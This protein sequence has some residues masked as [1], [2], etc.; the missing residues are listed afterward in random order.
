MALR[1]TTDIN[2]DFYDK[3]YILINAKQNDKKS[4]FLLITCYDH[5][6][7]YHINSVEYSAYIRYKKSDEYGVFNFCEINNKGKIL[8]ELTEQMLSTSGICYADLVIINKGSAVVD[9]NTGEIAMIDNS[10]ILSTMTFCIDVS[11]TAFDNSEIESSYEYDGLNDL[12]ERAEAEYS[13]VV[14]MAKSYAVGGTDER[15]NEDTDNAKYYYEQS[16]K[17]SANAETYMNAASNS[18]SSARESAVDA[19]TSAQNAQT[20]M[21]QAK[22]Y[23]DNAQVSANEAATSASAAATSETN[24]AKSATNAQNSMTSASS[25]AS[26]ASQ[27]ATGA[28]NYYLQAEAIVNGLNGAFL[29]KGTITFAELVELKESGAMAAGH[30][31]QISDDFTTDE[32]FRVSGKVCGAGTSVYY[33]VDD[34]FDVFVG[35][36]VAGVKGESETGYRTGMVNI[37]PENVGAIPTAD[38]ATVDEVKNYLSII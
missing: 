5:G 16:K 15:V 14:R 7:I 31:Y 4:R 27:S 26:S 17:N 12:M 19:N 37:T 35:A 18:A 6:E 22:T 11:E 3:K 20:Y 24:A 33:T 30:M 21:G 32:N 23:M 13:D 29:P 34:K 9:E 36:T 38:I 25:S 1:T 8:V 10:G 28:Q 2:V